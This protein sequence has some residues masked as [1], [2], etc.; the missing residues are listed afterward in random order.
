MLEIEYVN[1]SHVFS[2]IFLVAVE[3]SVILRKVFKGTF[4]VMLAKAES[5][6]HDK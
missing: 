2:T 1:L 5:V 4:F 3:R 6:S